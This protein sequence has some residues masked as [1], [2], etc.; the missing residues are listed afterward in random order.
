LPELSVDEWNEIY[1]EMY[2]ELH[3]LIAKELMEQ[4]R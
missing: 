3:D 1:L 2:N 4:R